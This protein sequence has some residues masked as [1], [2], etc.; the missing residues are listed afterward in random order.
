MVESTA[1]ALF[2]AQPLVLCGTG[3]FVLSV[4]G[5]EIRFQIEPALFQAP[6]EFAVQ[7]KLGLGLKIVH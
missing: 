7:F 6:A 4:G 2:P 5:I 1:N 3:L